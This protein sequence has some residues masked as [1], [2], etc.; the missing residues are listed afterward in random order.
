MLTFDYLDIQFEKDDK[1]KI[2]AIWNGN[3]GHK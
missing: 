1:T 3:N 2:A